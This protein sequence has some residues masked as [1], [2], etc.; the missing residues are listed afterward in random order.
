M[1]MRKAQ[2]PASACTQCAVY[3]PSNIRQSFTSSPRYGHLDQGSLN[4][5]VRRGTPDD[6]A[7]DR[8]GVPKRE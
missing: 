5:S 4:V 1:Q 3:L 6:R 8:G 2:H 7:Q